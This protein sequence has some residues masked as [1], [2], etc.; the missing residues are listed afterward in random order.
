M[1]T[2]SIR[3]KTLAIALPLAGIGFVGCWDDDDNDSGTNPT[4]QFPLTAAVADVQGY[5][6]STIHGTVTFKEQGDSLLVQ[7]SIAGLAP[8]QPY[9]VHVHQ[10]GDCSAPEASGD[11]FAGP[12]EPHG[13]PFGPA[14]SHHRG[15][16]P[17]LQVDSDGVGHFE[18][19]A[20]SIS[21]GEGVDPGAILNIGTPIDTGSTSVLGR[22]VVVHAAPD[23]YTTQPSGASDGRIACGVI[24]VTDSTGTIQ[25]TTGT[26]TDT[27]GT[28]I[29]TTGTLPI[30]TT[31]SDTLTVPV[32]I[33][34]TGTPT[35]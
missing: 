1:K 17:N 8:G 15:D 34:S 22:S 7:G 10:F 14:G 13:N 20:G 11:H 21:L 16:L 18:I 27:T 26:G 32:P 35:Y 19:M 3:A 30:D 28:G 23:D 2:L 12:G 31:G 9:A 29:D 33:D 6:D 4:S 25:D 5:T 24:H